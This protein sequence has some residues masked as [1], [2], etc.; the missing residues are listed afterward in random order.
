[1]NADS[2]DISL[3]LCRHPLNNFYISRDR[4]ICPICGSFYDNKYKDN[5]FVYDD[6][7]PEKRSHFDKNVLKNKIKSARNFISKLD[8]SLEGKNVLEVGFGS[9]DTLPIYKELGAITFGL[10]AVK[11]NVE[12]AVKLGIDRK[13]LFLVEELPEEFPVKIDVFVFFDSFEHI[14]DQYKFVEWMRKNSASGAQILLIA[15]KA[16]SL[17]QKIMWPF[18]AHRIPDHQ[19]HW[20]EPGLIDLFKGYSFAKIKSFLPLKSVTVRTLVIHVGMIFQIKSA[21][22]L[23]VKIFNPI[24]NISLWFNIGEHGLIFKSE[25]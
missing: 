16:D 4:T 12:N 13:N 1:M 23:L 15:P 3:S 24:L 18:W 20:S 10:E 21:P 2:T 11:I 6:S 25:V 19:F 22:A 17:S 14:P 5:N 8:I 7:Y 9:G